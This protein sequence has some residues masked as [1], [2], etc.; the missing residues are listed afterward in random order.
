MLSKRVHCIVVVFMLLSSLN[1]F[2]KTLNSVHYVK[3]PQ[4]ISRK[5][6][7]AFARGWV[8]LF[9]WEA[10]IQYL[11]LSP[12]GSSIWKC[13]PSSSNSQKTSSPNQQENNLLGLRIIFTPEILSTTFVALLRLQ[14]VLLI[15]KEW[16]WLFSWV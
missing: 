9:F 15:S 8:G 12:N 4:K 6:E 5:D 1:F 16:S 11:E 10:P 3:I 13:T 14:K 2:F 7:T